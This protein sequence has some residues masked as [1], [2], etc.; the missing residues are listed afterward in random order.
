M[1]NKFRTRKRKYLTKKV[2]NLIFFQKLNLA[3][4]RC[5]LIL[6]KFFLLTGKLDLVGGWMDG[7]KTWFM[8]LLSAVSF[9]LQPLG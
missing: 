4:K 2:N 5:Q 8:G 3:S 9:F 6:V 1:I 7:S